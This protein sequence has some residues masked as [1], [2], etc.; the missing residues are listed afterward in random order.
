MKLKSLVGVGI[1]SGSVACLSM[2]C[3]AKTMLGDDGASAGRVFMSDQPG[4][5]GSGGSGGSSGSG[6]SGGSAGGPPASLDLTPPTDTCSA[7]CD[8]PAGTVQ[9]IQNV[10]QFY[11]RIVGR[12]LFC[13]DK[14]NSYPGPEDVIGVEYEEIGRASC[15][16]RV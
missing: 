3:S 15:R 11:A 1:F 9:P 4:S 2:G 13:G 6:G 8:D 10:E 7:T 16:E 12:W 14:G 5:G